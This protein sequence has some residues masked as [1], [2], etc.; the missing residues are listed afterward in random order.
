[1][2][3]LLPTLFAILLLATLGSAAARAQEGPG[4]TAIRQLDMAT[5]HL[6]GTTGREVR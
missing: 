3:R 4:M 2:K 6:A 5:Q 1:M